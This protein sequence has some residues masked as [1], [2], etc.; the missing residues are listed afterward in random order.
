MAT[1]KLVGVP[2]LCIMVAAA[3]GG[4]FYI[5]IIYCLTVVGKYPFLSLHR[6][7]QWV[8]LNVIYIKATPEVHQFN[9]VH[10]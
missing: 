7:L 8:I 6:G 9:L 3:V 5:S 4:P 2:V 1:D 10:A